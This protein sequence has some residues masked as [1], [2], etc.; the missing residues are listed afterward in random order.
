MKIVN[1]VI[2][3]LIIMVNSSYAGWVDGNEL[4][5]DVFIK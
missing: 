3:A 5:K 2:V 1:L 4:K